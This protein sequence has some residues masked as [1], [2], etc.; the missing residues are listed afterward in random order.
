MSTSDITG[1]HHVGL[2][3]RDMNAAIGT[4]RNLG[5]HI[6]PPA[7]PALPPAPGAEPAP[8]GA[9][10]T[11]ADFPRGFIELLAFAPEDRDRLP[12]QAR[13]VPLPVPDDQLAATRAA[14]R[15][16]VAAL[17]ARLHRSE[18]AH[19]LILA[20]AD[21]DRT[22]ARLTAANI[23]HTGARPAQRPIA[24]AEGTTL[25]A[26]K[27]LE[28]KDDHPTGLLPEGRIGAAE[29]APPKL[30]DAQIGLDHPNGAFGLTECVLCVDDDELD[31]TADRYGS[32]LN[33]TPT[34]HGDTRAIDLG[35]HRLTITTPHGLTK[36]LPGEAPTTPTLSAYT[37]DVADLAT[38]EQ[39]LR[40]RDIDLRQAATGEPFI[41]AGA[42]HGAAILL[43]QA[44]A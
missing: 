20:T 9:G 1:L 18:G 39:L 29:D 16:T 35:A 42:A 6:G 7:Y 2:L 25:A 37:V 24:T 17:E 41:P 15:D 30:L 12:A 34:G 13:L 14:L 27:Y 10:N 36:R 8:I 21:A 43:R 40:A 5:F 31:A 38:A 26:I 19:I 44:T 23:S 11:H 3:V 28:I 4:F 32:Y 22:A 33:R